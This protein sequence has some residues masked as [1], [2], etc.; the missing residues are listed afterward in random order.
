MDAQEINAALQL[1]FEPQRRGVAGE[2]DPVRRVRLNFL[3]EYPRNL[4]AVLETVSP[5]EPSQIDPS[6]QPLGE[7]IV[8]SPPQRTASQVDVTEMN[9]SHHYNL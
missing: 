8:R 9:K 6:R 7:K 4:R 5:A 1:V 2:N 3:D